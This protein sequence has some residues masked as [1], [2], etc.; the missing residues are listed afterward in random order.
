MTDVLSLNTDTLGA[1]QT[2][3]LDAGRWLLTGA[4]TLFLGYAILM[5]GALLL[6]AVM[7]AMSRGRI[8]SASSTTGPVAE[9]GTMSVYSGLNG[10]GSGPVAGSLG[11]RS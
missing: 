3:L 5:L 2:I 7:G 1:A 6:S 10:L 8:P 4:V 9:Q 11:V